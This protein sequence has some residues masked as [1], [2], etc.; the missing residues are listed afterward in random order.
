MIHELEKDHYGKVIPLLK[1]W[2]HITAVQAVI[3][4]NNPGKIYVDDC[5]NP[6]TALIWTQPDMFY[7]AGDE[8]NDEFIT[9]LRTLI[10]EKIAP[11]AL[12]IGFRYFSV[13]VSSCEKW[14]P[15]IKSLFGRRCPKL[16]Y[17]WVFMFNHS[18]YDHEEL[19]IPPRLSLVRIDAELLEKAR[20]ILIEDITRFWGTVE[21]FMA[22]GVGFWMLLE[23]DYIIS[24]CISSS[25]SKNNHS[26]RLEMYDRTFLEW[27]FRTHLLRP[28]V[29]YNRSGY[30]KYHTVP[31]R[32]YVDYCISQGLIPW[33]KCYRTDPL[34]TQI[35]KVGFEKI[36]EH[37]IFYF[38]FDEYDDLLFT[39]CYFLTEFNDR[40][41]AK[42]I[43]KKAFKIQAPFGRDYV[44]IA[45]AW[46]LA[47]YEK[48]AEEWLIEG[49][50][51]GLPMIRS[52][53]PSLRWSKKERGN[54]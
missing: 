47:G 27:V 42:K 2:N 49:V 24:S 11:E 14:G 6:Q 45:A 28:Y 43:F 21:K 46:K 8:D 9:A 44:E 34:I 3:E 37:P 26:I 23:D 38:Y 31:L 20:D 1:S 51:H 53:E 36:R 18:L 10:T 7:L 50:D 13:G 22:K 17:E 4:G 35:E 40:S 5:E 52:P 39:A 48:V 30:E 32:A 54:R 15:T 16:N 12:K 41:Y 29:K 25:V 33:L 19:N